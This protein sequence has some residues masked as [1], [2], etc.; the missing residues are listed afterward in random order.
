MIPTGPQSIERLYDL[1]AQQLT[2]RLTPAEEAELRELQAKWPHVEPDEFDQLAAVVQ[3]AAAEP[4]PELPPVLSARLETDASAYFQPTRPRAAMR[5][6]NRSWAAVAGWLVAACLLVAVAA[7]T[8]ERWGKPTDVARTPAEERERLLAAGGKRF[9]AKTQSGDVVW[10]GSTQQG[11]LSVSGLPPNDPVKTQYQLWIVDAGRT[12]KEPVDGGVFDV[13]PDGR[14]VVAI[15]AALP[16][17]NP[18]LF[19][20]TQE[21]PGGV[22]V[23]ERGKRGE[24]EVVFGE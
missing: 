2:D 21:P 15:K 13:G 16:I 5:P 19:A 23:S 3:A 18:I 20:V 14:A 10:D 7:L 4:V 8:W 17:R 24:F 11:Y 1:L 9:P 22:V 6:K 12:H